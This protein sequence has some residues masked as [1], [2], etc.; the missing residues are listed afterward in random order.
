[1]NVEFPQQRALRGI[2]YQCMFEQVGR[3]RRNTLAEKQTCR[4][5]TV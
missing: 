3:V 4:G 1:M 5:E 2:L